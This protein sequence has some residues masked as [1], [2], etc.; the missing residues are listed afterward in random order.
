MTT[1]PF[2]FADASDYYNSPASEQ[3][4]GYYNNDGDSTDRCQSGYY[5]YSQEATRMAYNVAGGYG[6]GQ[7]SWQPLDTICEDSSE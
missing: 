2:A 1:P 6:Y 5:Q 3:Q 7:R 4:Y